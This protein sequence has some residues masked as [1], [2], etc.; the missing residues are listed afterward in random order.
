M[1]LAGVLLARRWPGDDGAQHDQRRLV[2]DCLG[3]LDRRV[4]LGDVLF[5]DAG[6]LPVDHLGVPV[7]RIVPGADILAEGDVRVALDGNLVAVVDHDEVAELLVAG[8]GRSLA[9]DAFLQVAVA[10]DDVDEMVERAGAGVGIRIEQSTFVAC[11][12]GESDGG[13]QTLAERAGGDLDARGV[14]VFGVTG[15]LRPPGAVGA[16]VVELQPVPAKVQLDVLR[17]RAVT[18]GEH[19]PIPTDP[20]RIARI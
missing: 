16:Q 18:A 6:L 1:G 12:I 8:E 3:R 13:G 10:R 14:T 2:G 20:C 9:R 11:G 17:Q 19:E 15:C 7:V 4:Q 5:V